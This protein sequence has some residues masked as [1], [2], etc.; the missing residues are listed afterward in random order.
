MVSLPPQR[1]QRWTWRPSPAQT[2]QR[3][4][5]RRGVERQTREPLVPALSSELSTPSE[6]CRARTIPC[7]LRLGGASRVWRGTRPLKFSFLSA[8]VPASLPAGP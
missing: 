1:A 6:E 5:P 2:P 8:F 3:L 4:T 7:L